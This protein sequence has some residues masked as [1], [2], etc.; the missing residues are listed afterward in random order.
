[1]AFSPNAKWQILVASDN[2]WIPLKQLVKP[3]YKANEVFGFH[4]L[5]H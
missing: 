5:V 1:M 3:L 2:E 4:I